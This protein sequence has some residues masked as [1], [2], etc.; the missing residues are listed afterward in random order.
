MFSDK[1]YVRRID[2]NLYNH[3]EFPELV[4]ALTSH[5]EDPKTTRQRKHPDGWALDMGGVIAPKLAGMHI[6]TVDIKRRS[7]LF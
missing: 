5:Q 4:F 7:G 2:P 1:C 3:G 6:M